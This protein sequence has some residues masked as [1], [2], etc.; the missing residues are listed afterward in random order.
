MSTSLSPSAPATH[1]Q[2]IGSG[3]RDRLAEDIRSCLVS[4]D[5]AGDPKIRER[6]KDLR[7][8]FNKAA[9]TLSQFL[10]H[11]YNT[12]Q[13]IS[14]RLTNAIGDFFSAKTQRA[15]RRLSDLF[16]IET[17]EEGDVNIVQ[18]AIAQGDVSTPMLIRLITELDDH[19]PVLQEIRAAAAVEVQKRAER[20]Q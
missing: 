12:G 16:S 2:P 8:G 17:K 11:S 19:I 9:D 15:Q 20:T 14:K 13:P 6:K 7:K 4:V 18:M 3:E 10:V 5:A 1:P